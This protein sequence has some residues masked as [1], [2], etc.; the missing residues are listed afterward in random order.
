MAV[1][2]DIARPE[3]T[4]K[5]STKVNLTV[6]LEKDLVRRARVLAAEIGTS[7]SALIAAKLEED[8]ERRNAYE[9]ARRHA[10]AVLAKES[11][12]NWERPSS[13]DELHER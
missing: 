10:M 6:K 5:A 11:S 3:G 9:E 12:L 4:L 7:I 2:T 13:R 8:L 1:K